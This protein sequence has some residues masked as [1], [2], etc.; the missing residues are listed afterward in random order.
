MSLAQEKSNSSDWP[1]FEPD[2][3]EQ[4]WSG[5]KLLDF[6]YMH[7]YIVQI[8]KYEPISKYQNSLSAFYFTFNNQKRGHANP[9]FLSQ[10]TTSKILC[11]LL[12]NLCIKKYHDP[13]LKSIH[14]KFTK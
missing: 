14:S 12:S 4:V 6:F 8:Y 2:F 7:N 1:Q 13:K 3:F 5:F 10:H 11:L 9:G